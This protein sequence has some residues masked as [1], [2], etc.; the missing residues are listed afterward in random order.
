[1]VAWGM[2]PIGYIHGILQG[3]T[4]QFKELKD[5]NGNW[6]NVTVASNVTNTSLASLDKFTDY[7]ITV[8]AFTV[9]GWGP[10]RNVTASTDE[11]GK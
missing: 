4:V 1:M 5:L 8:K 3:Y 11:D 7:V 2:I 6:T 10:A 9:V